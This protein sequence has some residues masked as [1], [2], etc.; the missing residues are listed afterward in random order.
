MA[1]KRTSLDSILPPPVPSKAAKK[2]PSTPPTMRSEAD[3]QPQL[4]EKK[5]SK[6]RKQLAVHL[7]APVYQQ[8]RTIAFEEET[9]MHPLLLEGL[10][11]VFKDRGLPSIAELIEKGKRE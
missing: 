7:D 4:P 10:D 1:K 2:P 9:K 8:L 3:V 5:K 6:P 11:R